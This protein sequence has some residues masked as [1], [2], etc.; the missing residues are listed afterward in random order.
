MESCWTPRNDAELTAGW[1]LWLELSTQIWPDATWDGTPADAIRRLRELF[2][3]CDTI[4]SDYLAESPEKSAEIVGLL[5]S[6]V[7]AASTPM[8]LWWD[9]TYPLDEERAALLHA[10]LACFADHAEGVRRL[11]GLGGGWSALNATVPPR[12][13][14]MW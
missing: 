2:S 14:D 4:E 10:D 8:E 13:V 7:V 3:L 9:D 11:L 5:Q 12:D 6:M 1:R